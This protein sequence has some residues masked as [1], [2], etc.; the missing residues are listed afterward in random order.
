MRT[1]HHRCIPLGKTN[2]EQKTKSICV[3]SDDDKYCHEHN[4]REGGAFFGEWGSQGKPFMEITC[5]QRLMNEK[6]CSNPFCVQI[7]HQKQLENHQSYL[8]K[9]QSLLP[10][11]LTFFFLLTLFSSENIHLSKMERSQFIFPYIISQS[12]ARAFHLSCS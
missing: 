12:E 4:A 8:K 7:S 2:Y 1:C 5:Q 9:N 6:E 11:S 3:I 10:S